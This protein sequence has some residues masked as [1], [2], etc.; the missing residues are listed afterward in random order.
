MPARPLPLARRC[1]RHLAQWLLLLAVVCQPVMAA[2]GDLHEAAHGPDLHAAANDPH[3]D[4]GT[5]A[6]GD[7]T[8]HDRFLHALMC[9]SHCC[10]HAVAM[11]C[12]A[13]VLASASP[14]VSVSLPRASRWLPAPLAHPFR[15]PITA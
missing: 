9:A 13:A 14:R 4:A 7:G 12:V 3:D 1:L 6:A 15:P 11:P 5:P 10:G 2:L 8:D